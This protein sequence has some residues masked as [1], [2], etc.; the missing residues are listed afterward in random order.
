ME[1][2]I[3]RAKTAHTEQSLDDA[4]PKVD[5]LMEPLGNA[6]LVQMRKPKMKSAGGIVLPG[7]SQDW[8]AAKTRVGK[9][10]ALGPLAY[11]KR[12]TMQPW[13]EGAWVK[14]GDYVRVPIHA[15]TD[16][17]KISIGVIKDN[18]G[19]DVPEW[20][21]FSVFNDYDIKQKIAVGVNPLDVVDY[22]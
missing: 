3:K 17:W 18:L 6:V 12:E 5:P 16:G 9:V 19:R 7:E 10:I 21:Q 2:V 4:F 8:D 14:V 15:N 11:K 22:I 13:P 1:A 20:V